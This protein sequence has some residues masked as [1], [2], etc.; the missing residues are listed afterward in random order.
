MP[1]RRRLQPTPREDP[2]GV[3]IIGGSFRG[4]ILAYSGDVRTRPMKDR[5]REAM[6]N[7][8]AE[9][10]R[11]KRVID[12]FAGTGAL[13]FEAL[14]RGAARATL[15]ERHLP[16]AKLIEQNARTLGVTDRVE[17]CFSDAFIWGKR[18]AAGTL[19]ETSEAAAVSQPLAV[20]CSPPFDFYVSR[21]EEMLRLL[22]Q[23]WDLA[24][25]GSVFAVEADER[26]DFAL[27]PQ[28]ATW[29]VRAYPPAVIGIGE[30]G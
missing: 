1:S 29:F 25:A 10:I 21:L 26:F 28:P 14:S 11:G 6:F 27:L 23:L 22:S 30:K 4:R 20:F 2:T 8:L 13:A 5:V 16:T 9:R 15:I 7:L 17:V 12:L 18:F 19:P 24:P 3:R